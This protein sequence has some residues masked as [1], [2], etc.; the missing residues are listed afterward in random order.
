MKK[1]FSFVAAASLA[2][3]V[4]AATVDYTDLTLEMFQQWNGVDASA[5]LG[6]P[7]HSWDRQI[8]LDVSTGIVYGNPNVVNTLYADLSSYDML[9]I[10]VT[11]GAPRCQFNRVINEGNLPIET[12]RDAQYQTSAPGEVEGTTVFTIDLAKIVKDCG[13][14]HLNAIKGANWNDVTVTSLQLGTFVPESGDPIAPNPAAGNAVALTTDMFGS[15]TSQFADGERTGTAGCAYTLGTSTG[16]PYGDGNVYYRNYANLDEYDILS[17]RATAGQPRFLLNRTVDN[18]DHVGIPNDAAATARYQTV[19]DNQDG[20]KTYNINL[21]L[22]KEDFG[23]AHL[24]AIKGANWQDVNVA[25]MIVGKESSLEVAVENAENGKFYTTFSSP[26]AFLAPEGVKAYTGKVEGGWLTLTELTSAIIPA[27]T[28]LVIESEVAT[29]V[30]VM[31]VASSN[32][33]G[34]NAFSHTANGPVE[35]YANCFGLTQDAEQNI[36]VRPISVGV[37]IPAGKAYLV[38][39]AP[40][41]VRIRFDET[42]AISSVQDAQAIARMFDLQGRQLQGRQGLFIQNGKIGFVK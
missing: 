8:N 29:T 22:L 32:K 38:I 14:A 11:D 39:D 9:V 20:S 2:F 6:D 23:F 7:I 30:K 41:G 26:Y 16:Q 21:N 19:V 10:T 37:E 36:V 34:S 24:H 28:G 4:S 13:F 18:A 1:L 5:T 25:E 33:G 27:N 15:W 35:A 17:V 12:P 3:S 42:T 31:P 40:A